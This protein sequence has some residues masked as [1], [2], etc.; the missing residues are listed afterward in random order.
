MDKKNI[1]VEIE[2]NILKGLSN[3]SNR[4]NIL[5]EYKIL[6]ENKIL[7]KF[8]RSEFYNEIQNLIIK[9][10]NNDEILNELYEIELSIIGHCSEFGIKS[11]IDEPNDREVLV[12]YVR[13]LIWK[14]KND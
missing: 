6:Y 5:Q 13:S 11:F 14:N 3:N 9:Y 8:S 4:N 2:R 12:P 1:I 7:K 10:D